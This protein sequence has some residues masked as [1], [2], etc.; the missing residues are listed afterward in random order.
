MARSRVVFRIQVAHIIHSNLSG[1]SSPFYPMAI[2]LL[3]IDRDGAHR[4][5]LCAMLEREHPSWRVVQAGSVAQAKS[6]LLQ[7]AFDVALVGSQLPDGSAFDLLLA[8]GQ[9]PAVI[10]VEEGGEAAAARALREGFVDYLIQDARQGYLL[11]VPGQVLGA[12]DKARL[13]QAFQQSAALSELALEGAGLGFWQRNLI[14]GEVR[15]SQRWLEMLGL[16]EA[17]LQTSTDTW[18]RLVHPED[19][20]LLQEALNDYLIGTQ[21]VYET[22]YRMRHRDGH[23]IWVASRGRVVEWTSAGQASL[24]S[25]TFM[26]VTRATVPMWPWVVSTGCCKP[27]PGPRTP[28]SARPNPVPPSKA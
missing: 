21:A 28:S 27:S 10:M 26:D 4:T 6:Q 13:E 23:W 1:S 24:I 2:A 9:I 8:L 15:L 11:T 19:W 5:A 22:E 20:A 3:L 17:V 12:V 25:G 7:G 18:Q 14:T 16:D